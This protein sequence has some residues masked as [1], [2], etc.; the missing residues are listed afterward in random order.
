MKFPGKADELR[1]Y[2]SRNILLLPIQWHDILRREPQKSRI[3]EL[4][5]HY[6]HAAYRAYR[7]HVIV[8]VILGQKC[9]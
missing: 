8:F 6:R 4:L 9:F 5:R 7:K 3:A 2:G 1:N